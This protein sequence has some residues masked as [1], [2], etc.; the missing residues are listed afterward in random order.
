MYIFLIKVFK[1]VK[2]DNVRLF[3][4][5]DICFK[6]FIYADFFGWGIKGIKNAIED[7]FYLNRD[8][9]KHSNLFQINSRAL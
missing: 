7:F 9:K 2:V 8:A 6:M 3:V 1:K 4:V 5:L